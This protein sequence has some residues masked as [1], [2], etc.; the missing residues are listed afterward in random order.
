MRPRRRHSLCTSAARSGAAG[1][2]R[3]GLSAVTGGSPSPSPAA[4]A[5]RPVSGS[6]CGSTSSTPIIR[7]RPR[8]SPTHGNSRASSW[9]WSSIRVPSAAARSARRFSR[10]WARVAVP[11]AMAS[12]LPRKVAVSAPGSQASRSSRWTTTASGR[13]PPM[14]LE[15]TITSGVTPLC[16]TAQK[17]PVR[18]TPVSISSTISGTDRS[19]VSCRMRRSQV[20]GAGIT[21]PSP[22]TGSTI[23]PAGAGTPEPGSSSTDAVQWAARSAPRSPPTPNGQR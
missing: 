18:P 13:L 7:P 21:P 20:S 9:S 14:A 11:A 15:R 3:R 17:A 16:S 4:P 10:T 23:I 19:A 8:T 5:P 1:C 22:G 6:A 12:W 2:G